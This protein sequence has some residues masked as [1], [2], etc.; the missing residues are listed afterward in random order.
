MI[1]QGVV[2]HRMRFLDVNIGWPGSCND[3]RVLRNSGLYRLCQGRDR[4]AGPAVEHMGL[5]ILEYIVGH[6]GY[7]LLPWLMIP[8]QRPELVSAS[9][10]TTRIIVERAF[11]G[12][13][14]MWKYVGGVI[15]NPNISTLPSAIHACCILHNIMMD[16]DIEEEARPSFYINDPLIDNPFLGDI[17]GDI[18]DTPEG[19]G[20]RQELMEYLEM[21]EIC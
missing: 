3:R 11:G 15:R 2:D 4:L 10:R 17:S 1:V 5:T 14:E 21:Q 19:I 16:I 18:A 13:K 8:F 7:V 12:L 6:G 9:H 20:A